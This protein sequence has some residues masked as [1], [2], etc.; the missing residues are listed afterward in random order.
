MV[1][2]PFLSNNILVRNSKIL[3]WG[4]GGGPRG[5]PEGGVGG[6]RGGGGVV[7][8]IEEKIKNSNSPA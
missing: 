1:V 5:G 7:R 6:R 2:L 4:A 8:N 3:V